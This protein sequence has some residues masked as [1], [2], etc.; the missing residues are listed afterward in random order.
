[1][2]NLIG[3]AILVCFLL[4]SLRMATAG[5]LPAPKNKLLAFAT[6]TG[7]A[8]PICFC[9]FLMAGDFAQ[10][11]MSP[12]PWVAFQEENVNH[13]IFSGLLAATAVII[14]DLWLLWIPAHLY[15]D[16]H[17]DADKR[18][19]WLV[20]ALNATLGMLLLTP[21]NPIHNLIIWSSG[22]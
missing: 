9:V 14:A 18:T 11:A 4:A 20:R 16:K 5:L 19:Q 10:Q 3:S 1:M 15:L 13:G 7:W 22:L 8:I 12:L 17:P 21:Y 2:L 6:A